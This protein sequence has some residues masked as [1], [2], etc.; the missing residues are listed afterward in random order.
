[1]TRKNRIINV[2][3]RAHSEDN[4]V[5]IRLEGFKGWD[6]PRSFQKTSACS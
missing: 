4:K 2:L 1:M 3:N 6:K 5:M